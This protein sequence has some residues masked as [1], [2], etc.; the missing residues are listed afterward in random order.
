M[1]H[2][3][4]RSPRAWKAHFTGGCISL[5]KSRLKLEQTVSIKAMGVP[6]SNSNSRPDS[7]C[8]WSNLACANDKEKTYCKDPTV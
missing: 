7:K 8:R 2:I 6:L 3:T 5:P 4:E 1:F